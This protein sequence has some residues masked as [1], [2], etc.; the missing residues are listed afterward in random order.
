MEA[1]A[2]GG[3]TFFPK[4]VGGKKGQGGEFRFSP[5][6]THPLK[7][8]RRGNCD[9]PFLELPPSCSTGNSPAAKAYFVTPPPLGAGD[10]RSPLREARRPRRAVSKP[11][12]PP[13]YFSGMVPTAARRAKPVQRSYSQGLQGNPDAC[14]PR[15]GS[16]CNVTVYKTGGDARLV[17]ANQT[18]RTAAMS[19]RIGGS[20][21]GEAP[22]P[23]FP[24]ISSGRNGGARRAGP[25]R[26]GHHGVETGEPV[27]RLAFGHPPSPQRGNA[28]GG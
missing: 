25:P 11:Q 23:F 22:R 2:S 1:P 19:P 18:Q 7:R 8:P 10:H 16:A 21:V 9:S 3:P 28:S 20:R 27:I 26:R 6:C 12:Q 14:H 4:K 13:R 15:R 17:F 24:P 5:P